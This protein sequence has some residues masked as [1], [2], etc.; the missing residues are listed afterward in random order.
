M[1]EH[2]QRARR[3]TKGEIALTQP[4]IVAITNARISLAELLRL[5]PGGMT[6]LLHYER[7]LFDR[8]ENLP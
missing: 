1:E 6:A 2:H 7:T 8:S 4:R 3:N 5:V